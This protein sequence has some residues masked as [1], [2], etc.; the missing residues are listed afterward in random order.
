MKNR[1][2][3]IVVGVVVVVLLLV[4]AF[5]PSS[6]PVDLAS[7]ERGPLEVTLEEE[8]ETQVKER[9][10]ISAPIPGRVRRI[11]IEPGDPVTAGETVLAVVEPTDPTLL[12]SR[13]RAEAE[14]RVKAA[15]AGLGQ[16]Q[17]QREAARNESDFASRE[18]KRIQRLAAEG[19]ASSEQRDGAERAARTAAENARSADFA[20]EAAQHELDIA[21]AALA[22]SDDGSVETV[23][24]RSPVH[25]QV[26]RRL[27][28]SATPVLAGEPLLEVGDPRRLEIVADYLSS[29]AVRI[30]SGQPAHIDRWGG[31]GTLAARVRRV[32]PAGFTKVSALG[33]EEQRVNVVLDFD[34]PPPAS[35]GDGFRVEV[36]VVVWA[37][38]DVVTTPTSSLFRA[39]EGW[40]VFRNEGG[41]AVRVPITIGART[42]RRTQVLEGLAPGEGV[43]IHPPDSLTD[44]TAIEAR[45]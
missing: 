39:G 24:L 22:V 28:E 30:Q 6:R 41:H 4:L 2:L 8:G 35:L 16:A 15:R 23:A 31:E 7:V 14:A 21:L 34:E 29:D 40:A 45:E 43:V 10:V 3:W 9:F 36:R 37:Q 20:V 33:V 1:K 13:S 5:R 11:E 17:A 12:D 18:L 19:I 27:H 38:D 26:L 44:G 32:D 25:G 42:P